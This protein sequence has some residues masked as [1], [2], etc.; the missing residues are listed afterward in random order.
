[1]VDAHGVQLLQR[2]PQLLEVPI[3]GVALGGRT[4]HVGRHHVDEHLVSLVGEV[5]ALQDP[6][7]LVVDDHALLVHHFVVLQD[8]LADLE[9]LL[10][11]LRLR[12]LDRAADHLGLD[13]HIVGQVQP[14]QQRLQRRTVE[15]PH[16]LVTEREI[17][18]G[19]A[20]I[21]LAARAAAQL[22]VDAPG[23]MAFGAEHVETADLDHF[24]G[25]AGCFR[26]HLGQELVPRRFVILWGLDRVQTLVAQLLV[27][28]EVDVAAEHDVGAAAGHVG[29]HRDRSQAPGLGDDAGLLLVVLGVEHVVR[30]AALGELA[31][32][33]P[34]R[35]TLVVPIST[36]WPFSYRSLTSSTT[37]MY[38]ASSVL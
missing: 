26:L 21:A 12:A 13:R 23:L 22:V 15:P 36:G 34:E 38:L 11:D 17:E 25:F 4:V 3:L 1:M 2:G 30:N 20:R 5:L 9:V 32:Q 37:A 35:S 33:V 19:L 14:G 31:R 28:Q 8:V 6:A 7:A 29:G 18:P 24:F 16:E 27:D 10:L